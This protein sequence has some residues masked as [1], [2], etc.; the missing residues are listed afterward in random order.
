[1]LYKK[2]NEVVHGR[3]YGQHT[4]SYGI[5]FYYCLFI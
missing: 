1:M 2:E 4:H 3:F 5:L